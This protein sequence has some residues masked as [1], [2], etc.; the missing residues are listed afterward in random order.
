[1]SLD[2]GDDN[3]EKDFLATLMVRPVWGDK[4]WGNL[5]LAWSGIGGV[6][7]ES[8]GRDPITAPVN[9]LNRNQTQSWRHESWVFYRPGG[10]AKGLWLKSEAQWIKDRNAPLTVSDLTGNDALGIGLQTSAKP[11]W[12]TGFYV[13]AGYN[14]GKSVFADRCGHLKNFEFAARYEEF[15][16]IYTADPANPAHTNA[17][18]TKVITPGI[19]YY[20]RGHDA[21]I[22]A[23]YN[24]VDNPDGNNA[25]PSHH[26]RN[27]SFVM[28][29][30]VGF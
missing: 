18:L 22:Q 11:F 21:K 12:R 29:Y 1:L 19:N 23:N 13:S 7:G 3:D 24:F 25:A 10:P 16:T 30:Q 26:V 28:N 15:E 27:D 17:H 8:A 5:E 9:G 20:I 6:H 4:T 14:L 2:R